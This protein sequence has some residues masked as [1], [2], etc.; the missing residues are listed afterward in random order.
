MHQTC[1]PFSW[2]G[3]PLPF[4]DVCDGS[5]RWAMGGT[6]HRAEKDTRRRLRSHRRSRSR[7]KRQSGAIDE[8]LAQTPYACT[9]SSWQL[10][11]PRL[12]RA[13]YIVTA[14]RRLEGSHGTA[15]DGVWG[16]SD[17]HLRQIPMNKSEVNE[18]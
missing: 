3:M 10:N 17:Q 5:G 11:S 9:S 16:L 8:V 14:A 1:A 4:D 7:L 15:S 18:G 12:A 6:T 13:D 2:A